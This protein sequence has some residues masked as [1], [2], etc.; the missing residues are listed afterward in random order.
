MSSELIFGGFGQDDGRGGMVA[1]SS[2]RAM[3][4]RERNDAASLMY[5][6]RRQEV[7]AAFR[8]RITQ[9]AMHD[10]MD[11]VLL[12]QRL[13]AGDPYLS[14]ELGTVVGEFTRQTANDIHNFG[15]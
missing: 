11:V 2:R 1:R 13:A 15:R 5:E 6:V 8:Q 7:V 4:Q 3:Q 10:V 9:N 12:A 14:Q